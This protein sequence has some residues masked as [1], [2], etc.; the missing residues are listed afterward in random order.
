MDQKKYMAGDFDAK[1]D[2]MVSQAHQYLNKKAAE[3]FPTAAFCYVPGAGLEPAR[4]CPHKILSLACL[5]IPPSRRQ[6]TK[7][8]RDLSFPPS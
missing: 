4:G 5:P 3:S 7:K 8:A 6:E 1:E 2:Y